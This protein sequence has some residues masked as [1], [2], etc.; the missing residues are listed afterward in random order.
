MGS[1]K[2]LQNIISHGICKIAEFLK[3]ENPVVIAR[4]FRSAL[5]R[6][7]GESE[8]ADE[9]RVMI[10]DEEDTT[11]YFTFS[12]Q[13]HPK[14][15]QF[16]VYGPENGLIVDYDQQTI[17]KVRGVKYKSYMEKLV[18]PITYAKQYLANWRTNVGKFLRN[19][20]HMNSGMR[21]LIKSFHRAVLDDGP[22]PIPY[23]EII[24]TSKIMDSIFE[25]LEQSK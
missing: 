19:D 17:I 20:F 25:Q 18:P 13:M 8:I 12:T 3:G 24:L 14:F 7:I 6:S 22:L 5:L 16:R 15:H 2:L 9:L 4:G 11:A 23:R 10:R 1:E 21:F